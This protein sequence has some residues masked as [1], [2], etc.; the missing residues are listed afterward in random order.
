MRKSAKAFR[1]RLRL[2][3]LIRLVFPSSP[4]FLL[5]AFAVEISQ[6][7]RFEASSHNSNPNP[8]TPNPNSNPKSDLGLAV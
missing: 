1:A 7:I 6:R 3:I 8:T 4:I 2:H 5:H